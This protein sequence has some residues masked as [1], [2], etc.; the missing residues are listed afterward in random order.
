MQYSEIN[1]VDSID[2]Y[3]ADLAELNRVKFAAKYSNKAV[4]NVRKFKQEA[5]NDE[6]TGVASTLKV[7]FGN[8]AEKFVLPL[9]VFDVRQPFGQSRKRNRRGKS[10]TRRHLG[11]DLETRTAAQV[12]RRAVTAAYLV[13]SGSPLRDHFGQQNCYAI[14]DGT[15]RLSGPLGFYGNVIYIEH[16]GG[17]SSRYAHL[18]KINSNARKGA[19]VQKGDV[20]GVTGTTEVTNGTVD[21]S[22]V[23]VPHLH[24]EIRM[25]ISFARGDGKTSVIPNVENFALDPAAILARAPSPLAPPEPVQRLEEKAV[26]TARE[27]AASLVVNAGT[28]HGRLVASRAHDQ[29][30]GLQRSCDC[31]NMT[32]A[33]VYNEAARVAPVQRNVVEQ[34]S[35]VDDGAL[36]S[37]SAVP[38]E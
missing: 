18:S 21:H 25:N 8:T 5:E 24:F 10:L 14:A 35:Q 32:R 6:E 31:A 23:G 15:V 36:A 33:D 4:T 26:A 29:A 20:I 19:V 22:G 16:A 2:V 34:T 17:V 1:F 38:I 37:Y 27:A 3:L 7:S 13:A 30:S 11:V 9:E 12:A 28:D